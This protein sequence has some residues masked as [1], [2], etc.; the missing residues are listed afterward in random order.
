MV[1][2]YPDNVTDLL[3]GGFLASYLKE[4]SPEDLNVISIPLAKFLPEFP[5]N[6]RSYTK[7]HSSTVLSNRQ[8]AFKTM[9]NSNLKYEIYRIRIHKLLLSYLS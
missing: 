7:Q 3:L 5:I 9:G 4:L 6:D 8:Y 2:R 1:E